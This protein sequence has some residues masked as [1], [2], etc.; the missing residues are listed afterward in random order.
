[1]PPEFKARSRARAA[2]DVPPGR[3]LAVKRLNRRW[4]QT[5]IPKVAVVR[6]RSTGP[7]PGV[8]RE[9]GK[10]TGARLV[11]EANGWHI[12]FRTEVI[13]P[14]PARHQATTALAQR[15]GIVAVEDLRIAN[16]VRKPRPK[17]CPQR[18]GRFRPHRA[19]AK[20]G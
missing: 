18:Q 1:M 3:D 17:P 13:T 16:M 20:A 5:R 7:I 14:A 6:F 8:G 15:Y 19:R 9:P 12:V 4:A 10:L 11:R 2:V